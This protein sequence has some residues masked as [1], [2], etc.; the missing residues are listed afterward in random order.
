MK[1]KHYTAISLHQY[2]SEMRFRTFPYYYFILHFIWSFCKTPPSV[3]NVFALCECSIIMWM[4]SLARCASAKRIPPCRQ[5]REAFQTG[6]RLHQPERRLKFV[7]QE[8][9]ENWTGT[10]IE[11]VNEIFLKWEH[12]VAV[13]LFFLKRFLPLAADCQ[14]TRQPP[15]SRCAAPERG[16]IAVSPTLASQLAS[17]AAPVSFLATGHRKW[18]K[19]NSY[20]VSAFMRM[21]PLVPRNRELPNG[22]SSVELSP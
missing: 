19:S 21:P 12:L 11:Y 4:R 6:W 22:C 17:R 3:A 20:F 14:R 8:L 5:F 7:Y 2:R 1:E 9:S 10:R 15:A 16:C 18:F 13:G